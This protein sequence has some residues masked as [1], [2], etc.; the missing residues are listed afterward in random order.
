MSDEN[1]RPWEQEPEPSYPRQ[2]LLPQEVKPGRSRRPL[3]I[4]LAVAL[5][6]VAGGGI[7][8]YLMRDDGEDTRPAYCSA[9]RDLTHG[10]DL[11]AA[12]EG[13]DSKTLTQLDTVERLAPGA[14]SGDW[15]TLMSIARDAQGGSPD[16]AQALTAFNALKVI[17][18]DA[19]QNCELD[20]GLPLI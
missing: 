8:Y 2:Q 9:L 18:T 10:G 1:P 5:V 12:V 7:A 3:A 11:M 16:M 14:V 17:A 4:G 20:L 19:K 13:A 15:S 6:L